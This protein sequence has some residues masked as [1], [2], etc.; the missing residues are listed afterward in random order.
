MGDVVRYRDFGLT[1]AVVAW[2]KVL[3]A[4]EEWVKLVNMCEYMSHISITPR[5]Y[6]YS[7]LF[8]LLGGWAKRPI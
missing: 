2:D 3:R 6:S 1:C 4:P 8:D 7:G 5:T